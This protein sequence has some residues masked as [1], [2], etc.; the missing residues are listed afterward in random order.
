MTAFLSKLCIKL[1]TIIY[2]E[3][4]VDPNFKCENDY[5]FN[6]QLKEIEKKCM[7]K[8]QTLEQKYYKIKNLLKTIELNHDTRIKT[9]ER[10]YRIMK[11]RLVI[12]ERQNISMESRL[13]VIESECIH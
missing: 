13:A 8:V 3:D 2:L 12:S 1:N 7:D 11:T 9:M 4:C 10:K 6:C 5:L